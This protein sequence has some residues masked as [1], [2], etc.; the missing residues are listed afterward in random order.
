[1]ASNYLKMRLIFDGGSKIAGNLT[2]LLVTLFCFIRSIV[3]IGNFQVN[4]GNANKAPATQSCYLIK[5]GTIG[6]TASL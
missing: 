6:T 3:S 2:K 5:Y 4:K 1:M